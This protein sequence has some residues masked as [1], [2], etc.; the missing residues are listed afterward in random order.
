MTVGDQRGKLRAREQPGWSQESRDCRDS[1]GPGPASLAGDSWQPCTLFPFAKGG[2]VD[3]MAHS[4]G[5]KEANSIIFL[6]IVR[7]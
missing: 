6:T 3:Q 5:R 1:G 4:L 7:L 2:G